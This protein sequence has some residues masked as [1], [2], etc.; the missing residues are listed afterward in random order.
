MK[1]YRDSDYAINKYSD[2]IV[3]RFADGQRVTV[4]REDYL[5]Y[6]AEHPDEAKVD[7]LDFAALKELSDADYLERDRTLYNKTRKDIS[8]HALE[9]SIPFDGIPLE[10]AFLD[11]LDREAAAKA[12]AVML[13]DGSLTKAQERRFRRHVFERLTFREIA[14]REGVAVRA[15]QQSVAAAAD[16]LKKYFEFY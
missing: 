4:T 2:S 15:V 13:R 11:A 10:E 14:A 8:I 5:A 6:M 3:Y 1:N 12:F 16:K 7:K 9:D